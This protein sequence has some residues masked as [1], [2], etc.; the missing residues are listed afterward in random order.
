MAWKHGDDPKMQVCQGCF[1][2][3]YRRHRA[4]K[5]GKSVK[6]RCSPFVGGDGKCR[7][8]HGGC[9]KDADIGCRGFCYTHNRADMKVHS[10]E[11][12]ESVNEWVLKNKS[13]GRP[14][15]KT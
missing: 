9:G 2:W 14:R 3:L 11:S 6:A 4:K 1:A 5:D 15:S 7:W 10:G 8:E 13:R 12:I